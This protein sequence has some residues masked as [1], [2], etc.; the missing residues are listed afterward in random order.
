MF[1]GLWEGEKKRER[2]NENEYQKLAE[3]V[4]LT[5]W[6]ERPYTHRREGSKAITAPA[7]AL[8]TAWRGI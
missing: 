3:A 5:G 4:C 7:A 6:R 1:R 2:I 8:R